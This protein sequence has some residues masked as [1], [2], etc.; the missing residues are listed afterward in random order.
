MGRKVPWTAS[1]WPWNVTG[2]ALVVSKEVVDR[3]STVL[4]RIDRGRDRGSGVF[5][6]GSF[7]G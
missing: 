2:G 3:G 1:S 5:V 7:A 4:G 6:H